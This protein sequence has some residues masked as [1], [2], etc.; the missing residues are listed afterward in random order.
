[1][2]KLT[3]EEFQKRID[4]NSNNLYEVVS[5]YKGKG[6]KV[7]L[8]CKK[9]NCEF[10][11]T[12]DAVMRRGAISCPDCKEELANKNRVEVICS[13]C[14]EKTYKTFSKI[15]NSRSGIYFCC[16][17]HKDLAQ[18]LDFGLEEIWPDHYNNGTGKFSYRDRALRTYGEKC[19]YCGYD[20]EK[21]L[22]DVHHIDE[23]RENNSIEN[24]IPLCVM[25]H[26]KVTRGLSKIENRQL[27]DIEE[28]L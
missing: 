19:S 22:L 24:L 27:V 14:G 3:Q 23:N 21:L 18:T 15:E 8:R 1:M 6:K 4:K 9:H 7:K 16:R 10:E 17:E 25:C 11:K 26:A 28:K 5:E 2:Q 13:Y 20:K 12:A